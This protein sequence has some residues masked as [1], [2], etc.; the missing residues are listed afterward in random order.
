MLKADAKIQVI[1]GEFVAVRDEAIALP[2]SNWR[3]TKGNVKRNE[4]NPDADQEP[5]A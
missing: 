4:M 3:F 2:K 5:A 1:L